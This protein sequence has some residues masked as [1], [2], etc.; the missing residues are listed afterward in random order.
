MKIKFKIEI[1]FAITLTVLLLAL[2]VNKFFDLKT[3][4]LQGLND[5]NYSLLNDALGVYRGDNEGLC[6]DVLEDLVPFYIEKIPPVYNGK[7]KELIKVKNT[8]EA[9]SFDKETAWIYVN[10][11]TSEDYCRVF[12]NK[13]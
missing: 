12:I 4:A 9:T 5:R 1:A 11:K 3:Q 13:R 2:C 10:D 8:K 6:P 7:G